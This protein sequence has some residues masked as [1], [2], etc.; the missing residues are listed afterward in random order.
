MLHT[1]H[2]ELPVGHPLGDRYDIVTCADCG[3]VFADTSIP[4]AAYDEFYERYSKYDDVAVSTGGAGNPT[5][6]ARLGDAAALIAGLVPASSRVLDVGCA[7]GGLLAALREQGFTALVGADPSEACVRHGQDVFGLEMHRC[8]VD[9]L[10]EL[11]PF[12]LII[13]SHVLEHVEDVP[14]AV[15]ALRPHLS[16]GGRVYIEV[17]DASRYA[18]FVVAPFQDFNTEHINHFD[19]PSLGNVAAAGGF[20][21]SESGTLTLESA[22]GVPYPALW[23]LWQLAD[24]SPAVRPNMELRESI[25][26]YIEVSGAMKDEIDARLRG[27][28]G[29]P[30]ILWSAGQLAMKL[31]FDSALVDAD[32]VQIVDSNPVHSGELLAGIEVVTPAQIEDTD[33]VIVIGSTIHQAEILRTIRQD[34]RLENE[35]V[36][37]RDLNTE[38]GV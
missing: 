9:E 1:Q 15:A 22:P 26:R 23:Q 28:V 12:D 27:L 8:L 36:T 2:F 30:V 14:A 4:Q 16:A 31:L 20:A 17:P 19:H 10:P 37:L 35:V 21:V 3:A 34:L 38:E 6:A 29:R 18:E 7:A 32:V 5:D 25:G 11:P 13:L 24:P 33:A